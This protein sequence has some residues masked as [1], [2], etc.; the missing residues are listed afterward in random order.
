MVR[1]YGGDVSWNSTAMF[2]INGLELESF[3]HRVRCT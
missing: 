2:S 3:V 1:G